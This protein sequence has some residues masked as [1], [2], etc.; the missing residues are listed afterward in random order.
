MIQTPRDREH[1]N[2]AERHIKKGENVVERKC[3][4]IKKKL[5]YTESLVEEKDRETREG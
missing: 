3:G 1:G 4:V 2:R 5:K